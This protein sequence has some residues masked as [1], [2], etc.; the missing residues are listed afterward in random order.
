MSNLRPNGLNTEP[1]SD[2]EREQFAQ[3]IYDTLNPG[4]LI[5]FDSH[6]LDFIFFKELEQ[7]MK[8]V[9]SKIIKI[10]SISLGA[11]NY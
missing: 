5:A 2:F 1:T 4:M 6:P 9:E 3:K 11:I 10:A 8:L 7:A